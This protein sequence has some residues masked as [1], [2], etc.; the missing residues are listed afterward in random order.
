MRVPTVE[1]RAQVL[2][3]LL[4][5]AGYRVPAHILRQVLTTAAGAR[6]VRTGPHVDGQPPQ[7]SI[8]A[9]SEADHWVIPA[10]LRTEDEV[11][12]QTFDATGYFEQASDQELLALAGQAFRCSDAADQVGF[13]AEGRS[14]KVRQLYAYLEA[15][16]QPG[17]KSDCG[18]DV[19]IEEQAALAWLQKHRPH[20]IAYVQYRRCGSR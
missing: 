6:G 20:L 2:G 5:R 11:Y 1:R 14:S 7:A 4:E 13:W 16:N 10:I 12:E 8:D 17:A 19:E 15:R 3:D 9:S 18:S